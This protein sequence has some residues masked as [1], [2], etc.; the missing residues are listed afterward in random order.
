[1]NVSLS[2]LFGRWCVRAVGAFMVTVAILAGIKIG[3]ML[4]DRIDLTRSLVP[5]QTR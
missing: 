3:M 4:V 2:E 1:M 5:Y